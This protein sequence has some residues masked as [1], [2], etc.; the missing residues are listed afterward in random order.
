M[1]L[2]R[3]IEDEKKIEDLITSMGIHGKINLLL[4]HESRL[5]QIGDELRYLHPFKFLG[6]I[7]SKLDLKNHMKTIFDDY[8]KRIN[9]VNDFSKTMDIYDLKNKLTIYIEDFGS[10]MNVPSAQIEPYIEQKDWVGL[11]RFL[12]NY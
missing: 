6:Y 12:I 11:L 3:T 9:F 2:P 5:R 1:E 7:F 10:E 4:H 8:F